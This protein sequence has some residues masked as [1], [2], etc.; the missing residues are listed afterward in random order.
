MP[1]LQYLL[2]THFGH[3]RFR[4]LQ[5]E[6]IEQILNGND[7]LVLMPTGGGK[8]I[9]YQLPSM[10]F[11]GITVVISPLISLMK[12]QVDSALSNGIPAAFL[13]SS[14]TPEQ[15]RR[16]ESQLRA[17]EIKL[18]YCA[19]E[20]FALPHFRDFLK[21]LPINLFAVDEAHC[22]SEWGHDFR[23]DY[24]SLHLLKKEFSSVPIIALTATATGQVADDI[25]EQLGMPQVR[26]FV[27]SFN[28]QNL[29]Y[30]VERKVNAFNKLVNWIEKFKGES[31]IVYCFS[32]KETD[33]VAN[34]LCRL[35]YSARPYHAGMKAEERTK[36]QNDFINDKVDIIVATI[37]FGMGID[38][39]DVRLVVHYSL[40][41]TIEG[42]F[43]ETGRAGR[44][45]L[46]SECV[47]FY[48]AGDQFNQKFFIEQIEDELQKEKRY[49]QLNQMVGYCELKKCR[50]KQLLN[51]F[52]ENFDQSSCEACD[53]CLKTENTFNAAEVS[54]KILK[55]IAET[56]GRFGAG[57]IINILLGSNQ[58]RIRELRHNELNSY[59]SEVDHN[60]D[61]LNQII[62][63]LIEGKYIKRETGMY[64][65]LSLTEKGAQLMNSIRAGEPYEIQMDEPEIEVEHEIQ[66]RPEKIKM[67]KI[68]K[69]G[70]KSNLEYNQNL[71]EE[72]RI[73]RRSLAEK[74][75][76][77]PYVVA[78]D[79]TLIELAHYLPQNT[80]EL[81][82]IN[83]FGEVKAERYGKPFLEMIKATS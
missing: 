83:G 59:G 17:D 80:E 30:R 2:K 35:G 58:K 73:L 57:H 25:A 21:S 32:K 50:R 68:S 71:F 12:D 43:Q 55:A 31:A 33:G 3:S 42:Y 60:K 4:P 64:P 27:S 23:A 49:E 67:K 51:Y 15:S 34:K 13:N 47:L 72:F 53:V 6:I 46:E 78:S 37:A 74:H 8:S 54:Q 82:N 11:R 24:R 81:L 26:R 48:G 40:P 41:K 39:P 66:A 14:L 65:T 44:D 18:L 69:S 36:N 61:A 62:A 38:K 56:G 16:I 19:P 70:Q 5:S 29:T 9:C 10:V 52:G 79:K 76:V 77:P 20:R 45:G 75:N 63:N 7:A 22:I 1:D 28:R